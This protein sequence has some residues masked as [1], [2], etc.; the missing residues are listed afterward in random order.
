MYANKTWGAKIDTEFLAEVDELRKLEKD[1]I[2]I[3]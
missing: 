2:R 3:E 1:L